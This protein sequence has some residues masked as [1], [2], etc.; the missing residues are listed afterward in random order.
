[1]AERG[2]PLG[3]K[4]ASR[5]KRWT[6]AIERAI[7]AYPDAVDTTGCNALMVGLN[8]AATAFVAQMMAKADLGFFREFGDR[9]EGKPVQ[10]VELG[11]PDGT[12]LFAG[13]ER[14]IIDASRK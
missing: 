7:Q 14:A 11:N 1:M 6:E 9:L 8:N 10:A 12:P 2:A 5:A 3:N 4:N 13:I